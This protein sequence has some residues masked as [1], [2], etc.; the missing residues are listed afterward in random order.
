MALTRLPTE[1]LET[2]IAYVLP[3]GF[4]SLAVTCRKSYS[5]CVPFIERQKALP[6]RFHYFTYH[7]NQNDP[8]PTIAS[9]SDLIRRIAVEPIVARYIQH[10]DFGFDS[11][12]NYIN[13]RGSLV[14]ADS[15]EDMIRLFVNCPCLVQAGLDWKT[16]LDSI[17][18][19]LNSRSHPHYSQHAAAFLLTLQPNV[20]TLT[21]PRRWKPLE[22]TDRL[23]D[24]TVCNARQSNSICGKPSLAQVTRFE[25]YASLV[26]QDR[27]DLDLAVP[28]LTLPRIRSFRGPSCVITYEARKS[29]KDR[30]FGETLESVSLVACCMDDVGIGD[31]LQDTERLKT[32][33]YSHSRKDNPSI[34]CWDICKFIASIERQVGS[35]LVELSISIG[36]PFGSIAPG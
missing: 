13:T 24:A 34:Q 3:E 33:E 28:F 12:R 5:S 18:V 29:V 6:S 9:A 25:P 23:I 32:L 35:H 11:P 31:F 7:A 2:I 15:R 30:S 19:E 20:K 4:E 36:R 10:A 22:T 1:L 17:E 8:S 27:F 21:L 14:E 16:Y 26:P